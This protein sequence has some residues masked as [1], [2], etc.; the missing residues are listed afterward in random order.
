MAGFSFSYSRW[1][2]WKKCPRQYKYKHVDKMYEPTSP[3]MLKGRETHTA[4]EKY[5]KQETHERP[6]EAKRFT[7]LVD[8]LRQVPP[9]QI[10][11][12][13]QMAYDRDQRPCAWFGPNAYY[14]F[15]WDVG[16][17]NAPAPTHVDAVDWKTGKMYGSY[18]DQMQLFAIPAFLRFPK[19]ESFSGHL[20]YLDSG[21]AVSVTYTRDQFEGGLN[22]LWK[23]NAAMMEADQ[24]FEPKPSADACRFCHFKAS[25]GGPCRDYY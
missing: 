8:D 17:L 21:D 24:S 6:P 10:K 22:D 12:E 23:G 11:V 25:K 3:A 14:R 5:V 9:D 1:S 2:L 18:D 4:L 20:I 15:I 7:K 13:E 16:V 19:L